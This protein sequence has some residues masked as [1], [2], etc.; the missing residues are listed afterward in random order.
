[1]IDLGP[2]VYVQRAWRPPPL[3]PQCCM[4]VR[5][6]ISYDKPHIVDFDMGPGM[7]AAHIYRKKLHIGAPGWCS[8]RT[9]DRD[10]RIAIAQASSAP[11]TRPI[12]WEL[13]MPWTKGWRP[14][15]KGRLRQNMR[16][17]AGSSETG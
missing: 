17:A 13:V 9:G 16:R 11:T 4:G 5:D 6:R 10:G 15:M 7:F 14:R 2:A 1:M 12:S 8:D 3:L